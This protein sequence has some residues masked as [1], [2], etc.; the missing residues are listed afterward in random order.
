[1]QIADDLTITSV[2]HALD[3]SEVAFGELRDSSYL[4]GDGERLRERIQED[5]YLFIRGYHKRDD[6]MAARR[7]MVDILAKEGLLAEGTDPMEAIIRKGADSFFRPDLTQGNAPLMEVLYGKN[8]MGFYNELFG[9]PALHFDFTWLRAMGPGNGSCPH[10][11]MVYM[12]RGERQRLLTAW[13]PLG[14]VSLRLG[15][16]MVLEG[17]NHQHERIRHYLERDVDTYCTNGRHAAEIESGKK[18]WEWNGILSRDP[19]S[20][21]QKLGGR[22]LTTEFEAGDLLTFTMYTVHASLDNQSGDRIRFSSD[23]RYQPASSPADE[24]WMGANPIAHGQA[25]KRGRVC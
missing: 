17:S 15:G 3:T 24:R 6:V 18:S 10:C 14:D 2:K 4:V 1:M 8:M 23:S 19:H 21:Q 25:G 9:E 22:W 11:D 13:C 20:L 7:Y 16:L 5:G 12:G